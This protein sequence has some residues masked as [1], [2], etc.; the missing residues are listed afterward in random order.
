MLP[1][2]VAHSRYGLVA[3]SDQCHESDTPFLLAH[4]R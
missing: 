3:D 4:L 1:M 2:P